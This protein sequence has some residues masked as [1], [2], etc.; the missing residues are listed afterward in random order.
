M[1]LL[2]F[3]KHRIRIEIAELEGQIKIEEMCF[4]PILENIKTICTYRPIKMS[5]DY[6]L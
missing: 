4:N 3:L 2:V 5:Y 1:L 6:V